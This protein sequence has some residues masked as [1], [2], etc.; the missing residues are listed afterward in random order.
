[1]AERGGG[2]GMWRLEGVEAGGGDV[3]VGGMGVM[4]RDY[5]F[6]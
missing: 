5:W 3:K 6:L 1:M 4:G 2:I